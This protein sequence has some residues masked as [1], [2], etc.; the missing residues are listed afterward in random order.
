MIP[1]IEGGPKVS[2]LSSLRSEE[3]ALHLPDGL[4]RH[5]SWGM[6]WQFGSPAYWV[7]LTRQRLVPPANNSHRL[8]DTL[9]E[10][11]VACLLGGYG[12]KY[13][14]NVAAFE[15][16]R[17]AGCIDGNLCDLEER[18][19]AVLTSP[20]SVGERRVH[21]RYPFQRAARVAA[22]LRRLRYEDAPDDAQEARQW[23]LTFAGIGPKTA[24]WVVRNQY[25]D[26]M[27]AII[28]VHVHRAA[29]RAGIFDPD[30]TPARNYW[31]ME[32]AFLEWARYGR[33]NSADLD[34]VIWREQAL[35]ARKNPRTGR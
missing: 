13:E 28:D 6:P 30:W 4:V 18:L 35:A 31:L 24:S 29:V 34:A 12:V 15:A 5:V 32:E 3:I 8:A 33:V 25:A 10:E 17:A 9:A 1:G 11:V 22:A 21:Y 7:E 14:V 26:S 19:V 16:V 27:V 20:L 23:L 2:W